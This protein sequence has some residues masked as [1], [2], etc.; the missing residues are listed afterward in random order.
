MVRVF[1]RL[2]KQVEDRRDPT[3][4]RWVPLKVEVYET[5]GDLLELFHFVAQ[6]ALAEEGDNPSPAT[7]NLQAAYVE[8][9]QKLEQAVKK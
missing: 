1:G 6:K 4:Q 2:K 5:F 9:R 3:R 8:F 7:V